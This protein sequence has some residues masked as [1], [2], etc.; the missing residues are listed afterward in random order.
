MDAL[1][2]VF[3]SIIA[4]RQIMTRTGVG[5][6]ANAIDVSERIIVDLLTDRPSA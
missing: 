4:N 2:N 6:D 5:V 1:L 3:H